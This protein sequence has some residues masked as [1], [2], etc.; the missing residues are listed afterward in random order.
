[1]I[2][3]WGSC[4]LAQSNLFSKEILQA[5]KVAVK[6][7]HREGTPPSNARVKALWNEF[8]VLRSCGRP[9]HRNL[10]NFKE[11]IITPSYAL[12]VMDYYQQVG[13]CCPLQL[14]CTILTQIHADNECRPSCLDLRWLQWV[15]PAAAM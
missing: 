9:V 2:G 6:L 10:V 1:M 13:I 14:S 11:F 12:I 8:K 4:W 15:L 5:P 3:N 7:V